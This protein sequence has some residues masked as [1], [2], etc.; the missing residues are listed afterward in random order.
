MLWC[1]N[2]TS[3]PLLV[4]NMH[5]ISLVQTQYLLVCTSLY[6]YAIPV[7]IH[8]KYMIPLHTRTEQVHTKYPVP[9][10]W[11]TIPADNIGYYMI[12]YNVY[13]FDF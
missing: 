13:S 2:T 9:V 5:D 4:S 7:P 10:T 12:G 6:Y 11:F 3:V 1:S 8:M